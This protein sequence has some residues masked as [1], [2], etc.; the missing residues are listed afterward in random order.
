MNPAVAAFDIHHLSSINDAFGRHFGDRLLQEVAERLRRRGMRDEDIGYIGGGTFVIVEPEQATSA[1]T[2][3]ALLDTTVFKDAFLIDGRELR[4]SCRSGVARAPTD[5]SDSATLV[6]NAEAALKRAKESGEQYLHY[7]LEM[8]SQ[9][10]ERLAMEIRLRSALDARQFELHY[11]PQVNIRTGRIEAAEAL[12][13]WRDP[14]RGLVVPAQF[15]DVLESSGMLVAVGEW[16]LRQA[17]EDC[18]RW[19]ALKLGPLRVGVNAS[20]LQLRRVAFVDQVLQ[21]AGT[22][23]QEC[24]GFGIDI[25]I[26]E[27]ALLQ[28]LAGTSN[29][30]RR[31][32]AAG[33]RIALDDFGT[34]YSSLGL[35]SHLPVD[36]LKIDRSF[37]AGLPQ[38]RASRTLAGTIVSLASA[39]GLRSVG[40]GVETPEQ[41]A[42][43]QSLQCDLSQGYLHS[44]PL[45][46]E[47]FERMLRTSVRSR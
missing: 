20:P 26:T 36:I 47:E 28:D 3:N 24:P 19:A 13:R 10:A 27:T 34:G 35:L 8:H 25:E 1:G 2:V 15:L 7:R 32:R 37:I 42:L 39:F 21:L 4:I 45:P 9:V 41:L 11:Q 30:L 22:L 5:G 40:E 33:I 6:Q 46:A 44:G 43:L 31:L 38:D 18:R 17:L 16:A 12:L 14:E 29:K 23:P